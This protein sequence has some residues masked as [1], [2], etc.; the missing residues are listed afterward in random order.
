MRFVIDGH[1]S[2]WPPFV[3][4]DSDASG[5]HIVSVQMF[6]FSSVCDRV[7]VKIEL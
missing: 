3:L 5:F 4:F 1:D 6:E 7:H 2:R